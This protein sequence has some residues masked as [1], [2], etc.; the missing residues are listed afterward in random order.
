MWP[1]KRNAK[2]QL[3]L[4]VSFCAVFFFLACNRGSPTPTALL[5][6]P[7]EASQRALAVKGVQKL[8]AD[9]NDGACQSIYEQA[10][11]HF[12]TQKAEEWLEKCW[13]LHKDLGA[14]QSFTPLNAVRCGAPELVV[15]L[16][17][18]GV[19]AQGRKRLELAW[20]LQNKRPALFWLILQQDDDHW[21]Q[22]P[23]QQDKLRFA[24][25]PQNSLPV[26][27]LRLQD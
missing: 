19:F 14:W 5:R 15:C 10:A 16:P 17:G 22:I 3:L 2:T 11:L 26:A 27:M 7:I 18:S 13:Q 20:R 25:P 23:D 4:S 21:L 8:R 12:R 24:D 6:K 9:W 1:S